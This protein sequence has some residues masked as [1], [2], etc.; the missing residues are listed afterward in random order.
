MSD[1]DRM[2][3]QNQHEF[4]A[5][6]L[7]HATKHGL[8]MTTI[9]LYG[10]RTLRTLNGPVEIA[11]WARS[12]QVGTLTASAITGNSGMWSS[13]QFFGSFDKGATR[14]WARVDGLPQQDMRLSVDDLE[15]FAEHGELPAAY[16]HD[17]A[18]EQAEDHGEDR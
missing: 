14:V 15:H 6:V 17:K 3:P 8:A 16:R 4:L 9:A 10:G 2:S 18:N 5:A 1:D 11:R 12:F 7:A 13:V